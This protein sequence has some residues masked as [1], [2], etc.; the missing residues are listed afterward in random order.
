M[1]VISY[2][3]KIDFLD[4]VLFLNW[5]FRIFS[6]C[7]DQFKNVCILIF[8]KLMASLGGHS[9]SIYDGLLYISQL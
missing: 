5:F 1:Q 4:I 6:Q 3:P 2:P 9:F 7:F 8:T